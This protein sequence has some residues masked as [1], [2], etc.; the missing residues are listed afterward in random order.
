MGRAP[1]RDHRRVVLALRA[2]PEARRRD[3][4][5]R[6]PE[7]PRARLQR[8]ASS[9][10]SA[11]SASCTRRMRERSSRPMRARPHARARS[12]G[13]AQ[14]WSSTTARSPYD[15]LISTAPLDT[16]VAAARR[17]AAARRERARHEAALQ[18]ALLPRRRARTRRA[19]S[20]CTG[21]TCPKR[22]IRSI[23]SVATRT[24]A[25]EMAPPGKASLYVE[26]SSR[27]EPDIDDARARG[28]ARRSSRWA[29]STRPSDVRFAELR[30]IEHAYVVFDHAYYDASADDPPVPGRA[31]ASS[32]AGR[33]GGWN[34]SSMEDALMFGRDAAR[35]ARE[36]IADERPNPK[37]T[38]VIPIYNE[39]GIL[40]SA[41]VD[42]RRSP[43]E[44]RLELRDRARGERLARRTVG[45]CEELAQSFPQVSTSRRLAGQR[46]LRQGARAGILDARGEFVICDEIDLCDTDF[47][48]ARARDPRARRGR[49]GGRLEAARRRERR[50][51]A[52][53][54]R[55]AARDQRHAAR[56]AR[57]PRHRHPRPQGLPPRAPLVPS[58]SAASSTRTC[59]PASS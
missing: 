34:Y 28:R 49:P 59:S 22:S 32:R 12:T 48:A 29:S 41:V 20:T 37:I 44:L 39:E 42:L 10:R 13:A 14:S 45:I 52:A 1:A 7:R 46:Q 15:A 30:R 16:L 54:P 31:R 8:A 33:Y 27:A 57:L 50:A 23:A 9:I 5:R 2:A 36:L 47:Y 35:K 24:S 43:R 3:R 4:G 51:P 18:P 40:R 38:I 58:P 11:A 55:R 26:L 53:A 17:R 6:R 25:P 56:R 19:A 21:S